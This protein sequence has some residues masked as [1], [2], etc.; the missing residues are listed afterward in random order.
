MRKNKIIFPILV[1]LTILIIT[2]SGC[3]NNTENEDMKSKIARELDY[4]DTQ[5]ISILN[6]PGNL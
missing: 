1:A 3:S 6:G 2:L 4:L 5:I